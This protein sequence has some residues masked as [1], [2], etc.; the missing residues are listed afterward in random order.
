MV[1]YQCLRC[2]IHGMVLVFKVYNSQYGIKC[3]GFMESK[4]HTWHHHL[5]IPHVNLLCRI[6]ISASYCLILLF[7]LLMKPTASENWIHINYS[8]EYIENGRYSLIK[9][10]ITW[11]R[12]TDFATNF[13]EVK[14]KT[15]LFKLRL[16]GNFGTNV[17]G[18]P[19]CKTCH[20]VGSQVIIFM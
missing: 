9:E 5:Q 4:N 12:I 17:L 3:L 14:L 20:T 6:L 18:T 8:T 2:I 13:T 7:M 16:S 11:D 15:Y 19:I 1:W 10:A